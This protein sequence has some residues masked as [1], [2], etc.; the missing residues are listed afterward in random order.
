[1]TAATTTTLGEIVLS[2][3]LTGDPNAPSLRASGVTPGNYPI[4]QKMYVDAKGRVTSIATVS[5]ATT[6]APVLSNATT[7][8][9]GIFSL[10]SGISITGGAIS[11]YTAT[12]SVK[13]IFS[14]STGLAVSGGQV[15][16]SLDSALAA[17][18][19]VFGFVKSGTNITNTAGVLSV[20]DAT[21]SVKGVFSTGSGLSASSGVVSLN[22][23]SAPATGSVFGFVKAGTNITNTA[24]VL[25]VAD[26]TNLVKGIASFGSPFVVSSGTVSLDYAALTAAL[27]PSTGSTFGVVIPGTNFDYT[28]NTLSVA[29]ASTSAKGVASFS[30]TDFIVSAGAVSLAHSVKK[31]VANTFTKAQNGSTQT[32][33]TTSFT[34]NFQ[35][36]SSIQDITLTG[37][38][39]IHFPTWRAP[40]G[41]C[42]TQTIVIRYDSATPY[43]V[44]LSGTY[45]TNTTPSFTNAASTAVDV[46]TLICT[47]TDCYAILNQKFQ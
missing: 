35:T 30:S 13:G 33:S 8:V 4:I 15:G 34:P 29:D 27:L 20:D 18:G 40:S 9:N 10:G 32:S 6:I 45:K 41:C 47:D 39:A 21:D 43:T 23:A 44:T 3:D 28:S 17:T 1:M 37:N 22:A 16:L 14:T 46:L 26:A 5:Y 11:A 2:G 31:N 7:S 36:G 42:V 25:S 19:S 24:G 38:L 12:G